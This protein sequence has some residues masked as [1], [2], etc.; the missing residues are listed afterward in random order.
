MTNTKHY[1]AIAEYYDA[2]NAN[3]R[4]LEEDVPFFMGQLPK[5]R[6]SI[7]ELA[8]GTGRAAIPLAQAGHRVVGVD[9]AADMLEIAR[10]KRDAVGLKEKEL[11]L[12]KGDAMRLDVG[13]TF[14]W[15]CVFFNTFLVF[16]TLEQQDAVMRAVLRHLKPRGRF[17]VDVFQPDHRLLAD[18]ER[19]ELDPS[20]FFVP[21]FDRTVLKTIESRRA[22]MPQVQHVTFHYAW[23]D[24]AGQEHRERT[25]FDMTFIFPR[26]LR[27]LIERHGLKIEHLFGNYDGSPLTPDSPRIIARCCR[28]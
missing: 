26:E 11:A 21:Q 13:K 4:V 2:E 18:P 25:E 12:I 24:Q 9:F 15:V 22:K 23:F 17:W 8:V 5:R 20:L 3:H 19:N 28:R 10:R 6:Q 27:L 16:A 1:K 14:D 7:L